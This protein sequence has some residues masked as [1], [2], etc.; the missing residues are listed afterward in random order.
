MQKSIIKGLGFYV[1]E[2][3]VT[4]EDLTKM[5]DTSNEWIRESIT[6]VSIN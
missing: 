2:N 1:P 3:V 6:K 5:M 4:N